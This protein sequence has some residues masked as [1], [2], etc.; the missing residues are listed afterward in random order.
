MR[1]SS[2]YQDEVKAWFDVT[3]LRRVFFNLLFNACQAH[4]SAI[5]IE[6][7]GIGHMAEVRVRDNGQGVPPSVRAKLFQPFTTSKQNGTGLGLAIVQKGCRDHGGEVT[8]E[9]SEPG[10]TVFKI[11]L[12]LAGSEQGHYVTEM[13]GKPVFSV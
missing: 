3:I 1:F 9:R 4:A 12:P 2:R 10:E 11:E 7:V 5:D 13:P 8:L 6:V